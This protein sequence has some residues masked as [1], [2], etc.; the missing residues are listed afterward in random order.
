MKHET[1]RLLTMLALALTILTLT[2]A[3]ASTYREVYAAEHAATA[4]HAG[5]GTVNGIDPAHGTVNLTHEPIASLGW[6]AMKMSFQVHDT[7]ELQML[8][9]AMRVEFELTQGA[10]DSY[11]ISRIYPISP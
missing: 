8:R 11:V 10:D 6:P 7:A 4:T 9:P 5:R 3:T 1:Q 2:A